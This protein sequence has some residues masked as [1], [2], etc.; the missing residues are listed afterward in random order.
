MS[1][2]IR[3]GEKR[4]I[5]IVIFQVWNHLEV[6]VILLF[7]MIAIRVLEF[8]QFGGFWLDEYYTM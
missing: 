3:K 8:T 7:I 5:K 2:Y 6:S 1:R 4:L